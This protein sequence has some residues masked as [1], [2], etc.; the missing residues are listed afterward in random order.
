MTKL[1]DIETLTT[2]R[3][4]E[5]TNE[6]NREPVSNPI[7]HEMWEILYID[8]GECD[9]VSDDQRYHMSQGDMSFHKP[10][11]LHYAELEN[12][13]YVN[14]LFISFSCSSPAMSYFENCYIHASREVKQYIAL[15]LHE[16]SLTFTPPFIKYPT[17]EQK[18]N[19]ANS[20]W[21]GEQSILNRLEL[22]LIEIIRSNRFHTSNPKIYHPKEVV[23][24]EFC[25]RVIDYM[26]LHLYEGMNIDDLCHAL[27]FSKSYISKRFSS[28]CGCSVIK[29]FNIMRIQEAKRLIRETD[30]TFQEISEKMMLANPHY[31]STLF[32]K[33]I[34]MTP[35]EY[36]KSCTKEWHHKHDHLTKH[37]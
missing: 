25:S 28:V 1:I 31:F 33:H 34:G 36:K 26:E 21:G 4:F 24:D 20:L 30:L 22:M 14:I 11:T 37:E 27:S 17:E 29:Y 7:V 32:K 23:N 2:F 13:G 10:G 6:K 16:A 35:T 18:K 9:V 3:Y 15:M 8:R 19:M 12:G 5:F